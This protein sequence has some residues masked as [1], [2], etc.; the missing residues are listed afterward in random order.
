MPVRVLAGVEQDGLFEAGAQPIAQ[1]PH[2]A[3]VLGV[4]P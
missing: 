1:S 4:D 3:Q 2:T